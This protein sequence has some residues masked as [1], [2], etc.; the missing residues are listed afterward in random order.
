M[1][2]QFCYKYQR[3]YT[4]KNPIM[5]V[6]ILMILMTITLGAC[7]TGRSKCNTKNKIRTEMGWM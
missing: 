7:G 5:K 6:A 2:G 4:M 1:P 3:Y